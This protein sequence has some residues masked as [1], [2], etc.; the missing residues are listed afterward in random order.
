LANAKAPEGKQ[1][2]TMNELRTMLTALPAHDLRSLA[3]HL[4]VYRR[5]H[6]RKAD[7]IAPIVQGWQDVQQAAIWLARLTPPARQALTRLAGSPTLPRLLFEREYGV[8]H[9]QQ[10][11]KQTAPSPATVSDELYYSGL[12]YPAPVALT[13]P[14]ARLTLPDDLRA[15][16]LVSLPALEPPLRPLAAPSLSAHAETPLALVHDL[17]QLLIYV[18]QQ[19]VQS[20][21][22]LHWLHDRWLAPAHLAAVNQRLWLPEATP[23]PRSHKQAGRLRLLGF[24]AEAS[25]LL[26]A[27]EL[28]ALGWAWLEAPLA[29]QVRWLAEGWQSASSALRRTYALPD[30][31]LPAPWPQPLLNGL[32][33]APSPFTVQALTHALLNL[34][35]PP[36]TYWLAHFASLS[37]L[38]EVVQ[39]VLA[40]PLAMLGLVQMGQAAWQVTEWGAWLWQAAPAPAPAA[41]AEGVTW[42][43]QPDQ[44]LFE[45][46]LPTALGAQAQLAGY[47]AYA[48]GASR[49]QYRLDEM[50][51]GQA[52]AAG[53]ALP[54][55]HQALA[56]L[57]VGMTPAQLAQ[58]AAWWQ[59][60]Q[61]V[62]LETQPLLRTTT[63][64][65]LQ[66]LR[67][68]K[69]VAPLLGELL[70]PTTVLLKGDLDQAAAALRAAGQPLPS[71]PK[72]SPP[73]LPQAPPPTLPQVGGGSDV[74]T[75][76]ERREE[77]SGSTRERPP[78]Q[79]GEGGGGV[80]GMFWL[81]GRLYAL[82]GE[83]LPLPA[84]PPSA[85]LA[86]LYTSLS[87]RE[88]AQLQQQL[89]T[90]HERLLAVL[91]HLPWTPPPTPSDPAQ[92]RPLIDQAVQTGERLQMRYVSAGRNLLTQRL[93]DPYWVE[94]H[95]DVAY[96]LAYCHQAGRVLTFRLDR[97]AG[98]EVVKG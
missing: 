8:L 31:D 14:V 57:G 9:D 64:E 53:L 97:V 70:T 21:Q 34:P 32:A 92:W 28:S 61:A 27:G 30:A 84:P 4:G 13:D 44:M 39:G 40:E 17:A 19:A 11:G 7:W 22:P 56:E 63:P 54:A 50:T 82:L 75:E 45:I 25:Q 66:R 93:V 26:V 77:E 15:W 79:A 85:A 55:L 43:C 68:D 18:H 78:P 89:T 71:L 41:L 62:R 49:H 1:G 23:L 60:G 37:D 16:V 88:Q 20:I 3:I 38:D 10:R 59:G 12:L 69:R 6:S 24:L 80:A 76:E 58:L 2:N 73:N 90:L 36:A 74:Y 5:R 91:D 83:H 86:R 96:L 81:A 35:T 46:V 42:Q 67:Q 94:T 29:E 87:P 33:Q 48:R 47:A 95:Q 52:A 98:L 72:S 51:V 65:R